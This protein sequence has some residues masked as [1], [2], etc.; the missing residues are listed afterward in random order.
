MKQCSRCK[1]FHP[2]NEFNKNSTRADGLQYECRACQ[3]ALQKGRDFGRRTDKN[4]QRAYKRFW[5][6]GITPCA[7][8]KM[9]IEQND[10]CAICHV[11]PISDIDHCHAKGVVR[12]ILCGCCNRGLGQFKDDVERLRSAI[13]YLTR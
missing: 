6:Y 3:K 11:E 9:R 13:A 8:A 5:N 12:G 10:L 4:R 2:R 1:K 7:Y